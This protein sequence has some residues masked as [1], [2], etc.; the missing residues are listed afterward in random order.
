MENK[1]IL[2]FNSYMI[3]EAKDDEAPLMLSPRLN[4]IL[5]KIISE[6]I[7][8]AILD[9]KGNISD[10]TYLDID[11][12]DSRGAT[13]LPSDRLDRLTDEENFNK[14]IPEAWTSKLRQHMNWGK[15]INK[16][17]PNVFT[18]MDIDRF[19]NRYRPEIDIDEKQEKR[20]EVVHGEDIRYWYLN[21]HWESSLTSCMQEEKSQKYF[22]MYCNNPEKCGL[23]ICHSEKNPKVIIGRALVWNNLIKPSGDTAEERNPFTLLDRVYYVTAQPQIPATYQKYAIEHGWIYK[24]GDQFLLNGV[25]KTT[26][27]STRLKPIDYKYYPYVDTMSYYTPSTGRAAS[28]AGNPARDPNNPSK[29][30]QRFSLKSQDGSKTRL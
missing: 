6:P 28:T 22:D 21:K 30:F 13:Y 12:D 23:L 29:E 18:N 1:H 19:Y 14:E 4:A 5:N 11:K 24:Q 3:N 27:V 17:F 2:K 20:F 10:I 16:L 9:N 26:S 8:K 25:R 15:I 7:A